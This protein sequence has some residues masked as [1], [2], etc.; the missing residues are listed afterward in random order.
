[1]I[2]LLVSPRTKLAALYSATKSLQNSCPAKL[3]LFSSILEAVI[4]LS[5]VIDVKYGSFT[6]PEYP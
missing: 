5:R 3:Q 4:I 2:P 1:M 6:S